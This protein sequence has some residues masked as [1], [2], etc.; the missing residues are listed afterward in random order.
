[1]ARE[2]S[3]SVGEGRT[4]ARIFGRG[5]RLI[6]AH[7]AGADQRHPFMVRMAEGLAARGLEVVTFNFL[8]TE[9]GR[10]APDRTPLLEACWRAVLGRFAPAFIGGKSMGGRIASHLAAAGD[11]GILGLVFLGYPLHPPDKP[12]KRRDEHLPRILQPMLFVQGAR[13]PFG[14]EE[15]IR[16]LAEK[17]SAR[18]HLVAGGDHSLGVRRG[19]AEVDAAV[20]EAIVDFVGARP[21]RRA[22]SG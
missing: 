10:R 8:Y 5:P 15:E 6:L 2:L 22:R 7:G 3:V 21:R 14:G 13:D 1:V 19:Q 20:I 12:E 16:P 11:E 9:A 4:T 18:L 17:L